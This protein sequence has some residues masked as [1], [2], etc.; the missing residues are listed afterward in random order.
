MIKAAVPVIAKFKSIDDVYKAML[1]AVE[2]K[3]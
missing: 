2:Y 1:S 3:P